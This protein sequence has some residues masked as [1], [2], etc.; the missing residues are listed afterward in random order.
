M[1]MDNP[2]TRAEHEEFRRR[3][4]EEHSRVNR[5]LE[6]LEENT[7]RLNKLNTS[8]EKLAVNMESMLKEQVQQGKRLSVLENRDGEKWRSVVGYVITLIV[9]LAVGYIA[10]SVGIGG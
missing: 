5:R 10:T 8:I 6:I 1:P 3:M 9:G 2:I 4:E 7:E